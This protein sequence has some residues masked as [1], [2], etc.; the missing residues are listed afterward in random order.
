MP[1]VAAEPIQS[2]NQEDVEATAACIRQQRVQRRATVRRSGHSGVDLVG[3]A[4]PTCLGVSVEF[5]KPI[6][7]GLVVR[8]D[9]GENRRARRQV[10]CVHGRPRRNTAGRGGTA[11]IV[12]SLVSR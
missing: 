5:E 1:Q 12:G 3:D 11:R 4:P 8:A 6:L 10:R 2:P 7:A 9:A